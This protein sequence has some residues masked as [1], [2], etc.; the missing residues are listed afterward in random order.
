[1]RDLLG[2]FLSLA[3]PWVAGTLWV[4]ALWRA[5]SADRTLLSLGYGYLVGAFAMTLL[6]RLASLTGLRW[7]L[8][9]ISAALLVLACAGWFFAR[10]LPSLRA[11][12]NRSAASLAGMPPA[13]RRLFWLLFAL[14]T[15]SAVAIACHIVWSMLLP[16]DAMTQWADKARVWYEYG[17]MMPFIDSLDWRRSPDALHFWDSNPRYPGTVSLLQTWTALAIGHWDESLINLPWVAVFVSLGCAFYA[18]VRSLGAGP[19]KAM[20]CTYLLLSLPFVQIL[21]AVAGM[22]DLFVAIAYGLAAISLWQWTLRRQWQDAVLA[23]AMALVCASL[24]NEGL[25]WIL[26]LVPALLVALHRRL[27]FAIVAAIGVAAALYF[28]FGPAEIR[29]MRF[30]LYTRPANVTLQL[31]QHLFL[32]DNWHLLWYAAIALIVFNARLLFGKTLAPMTVTMLAAVGFVVVVFFFSNAAGGVDEESLLNRFLLDAVPALAF[33]LVLI[34]REREH[35]APAG[36]AVSPPVPAGETVSP[37]V[38]ANPA[39]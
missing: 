26:T 21:A 10:P 9:W 19:A 23:L 2:A 39:D 5:E 20:A 25:L 28:L 30:T 37:P 15:L 35:W 27:G 11:Q 8:A 4:R 34:L 24:K 13:A 22:A 32:M 14:C 16:Y 33:Y 31:F 17:R 36:E 38:P 18:Q 7:N 3:L 6:L 29:I 12:I 1:M